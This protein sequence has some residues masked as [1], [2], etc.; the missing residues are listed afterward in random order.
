MNQNSVR[1]AFETFLARRG[2]DI[3]QMMY[4][5]VTIVSIEWCDEDDT[6][7]VY[8]RLTEDDPALRQYLPA[9]IPSAHG[10]IPCAVRV[11]GPIIE[12]M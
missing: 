6:L 7:G 10:P 5:Y 11:V 4:R 9:T 3:M 1:E 8:I 12:R 2:T